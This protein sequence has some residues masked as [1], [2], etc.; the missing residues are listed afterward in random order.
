MI[1]NQRGQLSDWFRAKTLVFDFA[2]MMRRKAGGRSGQVRPQCTSD[3]HCGRRRITSLRRVRAS[4]RAEI[5]RKRP[6]RRRTNKVGIGG[7]TAI[8]GVWRR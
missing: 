1:G 7:K 6:V 3:E 4:R 5:R 2:I 8:L